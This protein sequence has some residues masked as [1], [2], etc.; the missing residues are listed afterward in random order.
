MTRKSGYIIEKV[1]ICSFVALRFYF[2]VMN[3]CYDIK[4]VHCRDIPHLDCFW[5]IGN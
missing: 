3:L 1:E 5:V 4:I 2:Q